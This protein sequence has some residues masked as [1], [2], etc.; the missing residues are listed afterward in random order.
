MMQFFDYLPHILMFTVGLLIGLE[1]SYKW[2]SEAYVERKIEPIPLILALIGGG[3]MVFYV[4]LGLLFIGF[5][6]GM[7]PGY[8]VYES[9]IGIIFA[10]AL[11]VII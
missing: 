11:W 10:L 2:H 4:P 8:G 1:I 5:V 7:R 9:V 6:I 3:L